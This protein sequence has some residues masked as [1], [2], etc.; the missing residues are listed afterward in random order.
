MRHLVTSFRYLRWQ[1]Q[2]PIL[3]LQPVALYSFPDVARTGTYH[4]DVNVLFRLPRVRS[5]ACPL[6]LEICSEIER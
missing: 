1:A 2:G 3:G 4:G 6:R 5:F